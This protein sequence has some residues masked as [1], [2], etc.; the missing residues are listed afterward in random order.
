MVVVLLSAKLSCLYIFIVFQWPALLSPFTILFYGWVTQKRRWPIFSESETC[1]SVLQ[2]SSE[3]IF[4]PC[5]RHVRQ[6]VRGTGSGNCWDRQV[7]GGCPLAG[8]PVMCRA[9]V[10]CV[11][12]PSSGCYW[13][14]SLPKKTPLWGGGHQLWQLPVWILCQAW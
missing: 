8:V 9:Q 5:P 7:S 10:P 11:E 3:N 1:H 2:P 14:H 13:L 12:L 6:E 4:K